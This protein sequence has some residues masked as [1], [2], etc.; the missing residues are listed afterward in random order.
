[1]KKDFFPA[2]IRSERKRYYLD[3]L[4]QSD[5]GDIAAFVEFITGELIDTQEKVIADLEPR[6]W[7]N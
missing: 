7:K 3:S 6:S 4:K 2:V 1:M 5:D